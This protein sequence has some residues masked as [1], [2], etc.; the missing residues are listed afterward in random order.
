[1]EPL[2]P[3]PDSPPSGERAAR[4]TLPGP[5]DFPSTGANALASIGQRAVARLIDV[6]LMVV[7]VVPMVLPYL[8]TAGDQVV[9]N[10]PLWARAMPFV[11]AAVYEVGL[12]AWR[13]Q[14]L[15]KMAQNIRVAN[16][17]D[18][19]RPGLGSSTIR[20]LVPT[21]VSVVFAQ[22]SGSQLPISVLIYLTA[23]LDPLRRG[24]HDK[25]AGTVVVRVR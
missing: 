18:G 25:A 5:G 17:L 6:L 7:M 13:G 10:A 4:P 8:E 23:L 22:L 15:G 1:M 21:V 2:E 24:W 16:V 19:R 14:T 3:A 11:A 20:F 9:L 12:I